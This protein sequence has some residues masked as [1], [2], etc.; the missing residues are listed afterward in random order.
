MRDSAAMKG[1]P[2]LVQLDAVIIARQHVPLAFCS[3]LQWPCA[4]DMCAH[5]A[6]LGGRDEAGLLDLYQTLRALVRM[7]RY[8]PGMMIMPRPSRGWPRLAGS[9]IR[10]CHGHLATSSEARP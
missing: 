4:A 3:V 8:V 2:K 9:T 1:Q 7:R 5:L 6:R 10:A